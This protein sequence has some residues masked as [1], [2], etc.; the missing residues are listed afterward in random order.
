MITT[1]Q[2]VKKIVKNYIKTI[3]IKTFEVPGAW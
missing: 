2:I 3:L 1:F